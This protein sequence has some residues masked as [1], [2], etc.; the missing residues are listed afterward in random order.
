M[1]AEDNDSIDEQDGQEP[2]PENEQAV[3]ETVS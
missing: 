2:E 3:E 1:A